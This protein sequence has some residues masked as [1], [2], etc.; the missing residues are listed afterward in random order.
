MARAL[1]VCLSQGRPG[2]DPGSCEMCAG[3]S[4]TGTGFSPTT[5]NVLHQD[6]YSNA[7]FSFIFA[8]SC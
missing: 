2:F 5:S 7:L 6:R 4:S 8:Y 1:A 3:H